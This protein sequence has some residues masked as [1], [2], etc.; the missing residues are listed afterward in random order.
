MNIC[1]DGYAAL[2]LPGTFISSYSEE[3]IK[4]LTFSEHPHSMHV[5]FE[6]NNYKKL[7]D[8]SSWCIPANIELQRQKNNYDILE[9]YLY[10]NGIEV[11]H[12]LNNGFSLPKNKCCSYVIT[13]HSLYPVENKAKVDS[14]YYSKFLEVFPE[15]IEKADKIIAVSG[16]IKDELIRLFNI[17]ENKIHV[18]YPVI[19]NIYKPISFSQCKNY[20]YDK[21]HIKNEFIYYCG[22]IHTSKNI[23]RL[24]GLFKIVS[25]RCRDL[26][27]V[28][29]G[30][31][32]GK[33]E[34]YYREL[35]NLSEKLDV[36]DR[37]IFTGLIPKDD[38]VYFYNRAKCVVSF[39]EYDGYPL[40]L[41]EAALC[42][43]PIICLDNPSVKEILNNCAV[44]CSL[45]NANEISEFIYYLSNNNQFRSNI[46]NKMEAPLYSK[47]EEYLEFYSQI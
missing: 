44:T 19:S 24:I 11:Y 16:F 22:N 17:N 6:N 45:S 33:K 35:Q 38:T 12:S 8:K 26:K 32:T 21:Y 3:L 40:S 43:T 34:E 25:S 39:S 18:I 37:V 9:R 2:N 29:T 15:S 10:E 46:I 27:L 1:I 13:V 7:L 4:D 23:E 5:I 47:A 41:S 14:K 28:I 42:K 20:I 30:D 31:I 36:K